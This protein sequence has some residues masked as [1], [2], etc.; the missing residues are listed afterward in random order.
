MRQT[1]DSESSKMETNRFPDCIAIIG[2]FGHDPRTASDPQLHAPSL[3]KYL[4]DCWGTF[5]P[6]PRRALSLC[7]ANVKSR[8][9]MCCCQ[10][11][12]NAEFILEAT[13]VEGTLTR[14]ELRKSSK[15]EVVDP[16]CCLVSYFD[17]DEQAEERC[18]VLVVLK[19]A[20]E[21]LGH[22]AAEFLFWWKATTGEVLV[23]RLSGPL[24]RFRLDIGYAGAGFLSRILRR[25]F[26]RSFE[27]DIKIKPCLRGPIVR[28]IAQ[29]QPETA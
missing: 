27:C 18:W 16:C 21:L 13:E 10:R 11:T 23:D 9:R 8:F 3:V 28:A 4:P 14:E 24:R 6:H 2:T 25:S 22:E 17:H 19:F 5:L 26:I 12:A 29:K 7:S 15:E 1:E 20:R